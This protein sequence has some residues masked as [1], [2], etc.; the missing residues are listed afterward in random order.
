MMRAKKSTVK[1]HTMEENDTNGFWIIS[2]IFEY[3]KLFKFLRKM[4]VFKDYF[5]K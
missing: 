4:L 2:I 1:L 5:T 3:N